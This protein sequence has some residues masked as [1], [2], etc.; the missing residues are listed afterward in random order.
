MSGLPIY[1]DIDGTLTTAG[2]PGGAPALDRIDRVRQMIGRGIPVV[3]WSA[4]GTEYARAFADRYDLHPL[5]AIGK[6][7]YCIDDNPSL[8]PGFLV[9]PPDELDV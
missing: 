8:R 7:S 6:P 3:I 1:I 9:V 4:S 2:R 5:A